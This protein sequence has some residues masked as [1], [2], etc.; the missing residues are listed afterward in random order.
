MLIFAHGLEGSPEGSKVIALR[1]AGIDVTA[2]DCRGQP[3]ASRMLKM[4]AVCDAHPQTPFVLAGSSYGGL[5]VAAIAPAIATRLSGLLLLAPA[6][7]HRED[8]IVGDAL[9]PPEGVSTVVVHG[10]RD[11]ICAPSFS[12]AYVAQSSQARLV[13]VDDAHRLL[14]SL[15]V[16]VREARALLPKS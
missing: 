12:E 14:G 16:I 4:R 13:S 2:P 8:D 3:L 6:L 15:D 7:G 5:C 10:T 11:T 9:R 1:A